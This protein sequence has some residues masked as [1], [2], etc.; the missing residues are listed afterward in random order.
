[1]LNGAKDLQ[2]P[3][4]M[5]RQQASLYLQRAHGVKLAPSTLAKM[6]VV[7]GGPCFRSDGRFPVYD[8]A[9]LDSFAAARLGPLRRSTSDNGQM[10]A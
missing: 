8:R 7:G 1:M 9:E 2:W 5:R 4:R 6:A 3:E 10:A